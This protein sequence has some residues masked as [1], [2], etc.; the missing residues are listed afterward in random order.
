MGFSEILSAYALRFTKIVI[1]LTTLSFH[2]NILKYIL[3]VSKNTLYFCV[4]YLLSVITELL[5]TWSHFVFA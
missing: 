5:K 3:K 2:F 1:F 4:S